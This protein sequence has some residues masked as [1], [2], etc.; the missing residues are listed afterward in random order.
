MRLF[1]WYVMLALAAPV[2][3]RP[4]PARD[5]TE[6]SKPPPQIFD[7]A[8]RNQ[9]DTIKRLVA[10]G[11]KVNSVLS[12]NKETPL[13]WAAKGGHAEAVRAL[14]ELGAKV[15]AKTKQK[16]NA[17]HIA[18]GQEAKQ[19]FPPPTEAVAALIELGVKVGE[20]GPQS[21]T[22]LHFAAMR[23]HAAIIRALIAAGA[24]IE[25][26]ADGESTPLHW[27]AQGGFRDAIVDL[28]EAGAEVSA[29]DAA[30]KTPLK[31]ARER[32]D[33]GEDRA[34]AIFVLKREVA[35]AKKRKKQAGASKDE[36]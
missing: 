31:L 17:L 25:S 22:P 11:A 23:G 20:R 12:E 1:A 27:A 7:A 35:A 36:V 21:A 26:R 3:G 9:V 19:G 30:G 32:A 18:A 29:K 15:N 33:A 2:L 10:A 24:P 16:Q 8:A 6:L 34:D 4:E 13:H 28:I 14:A 5:T